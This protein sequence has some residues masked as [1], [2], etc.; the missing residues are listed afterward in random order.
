MCEKERNKQFT[1]EGEDEGFIEAQ[2]NFRTYLFNQIVDKAIM[3]MDIR[4]E[5]LRRHHYSFGFIY[6]KFHQLQQY[7][8]QQQQKQVSYAV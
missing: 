8:Q 1:Y 7:E 6:N 4:F 2:E 5:I 3:S